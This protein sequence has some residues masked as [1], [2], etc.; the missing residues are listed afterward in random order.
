MADKDLVEDAPGHCGRGLDYMI[1]KDPFQ[2]KP[3]YDFII[4]LEF[5]ELILPD[6]FFFLHERQEVLERL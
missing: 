6:L 2:H 3:V 4:Q 1:L 5:P